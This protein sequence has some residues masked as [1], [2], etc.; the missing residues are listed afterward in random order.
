MV[1]W[2]S[3][4][5]RG[6]CRRRGRSCAGWAEA[7]GGPELADAVE[8]ASRFAERDPFRA[9]THNKGVMNGIDAVALA[10]GQDFRALEAGAHSYAALDGVY[11]PLAVWRRDAAG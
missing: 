4:R 3:T 10:T 2:S 5:R 7:L 11:R 9:V 6:G 1:S 8:R